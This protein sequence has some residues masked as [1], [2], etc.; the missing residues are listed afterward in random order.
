MGAPFLQRNLTSC[1][2]IWEPPLF[3]SLTF[4]SAV[5]LKQILL[6]PRIINKIET[7]SSVQSS[8]LCDP[9]GHCEVLVPIN[10]FFEEIKRPNITDRVITLR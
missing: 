5:E 2:F 1:H 4:S 7:V 8:Y 9:L 6:T 10:S 3:R